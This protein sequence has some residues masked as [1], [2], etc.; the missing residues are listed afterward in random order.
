MVASLYFIGLIG[1]YGISSIVGYL[2]STPV[3]TYISDG[4]N[5]GKKSKK[6]GEKWKT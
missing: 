1:V 4:I 6:Y 5:D 2:M 3:F